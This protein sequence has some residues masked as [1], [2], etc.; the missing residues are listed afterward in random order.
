VRST[1]QERI[2]TGVEGTTT[3]L[4]LEIQPG[5]DPIA[6]SIGGPDEEPRSFSGWIELTEAIEAARAALAATVSRSG[7]R[8]S[9]GSAPWGE[10]AG[11][12]LT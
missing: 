5:S 12:H 7:R 3:H 1:G 4:H 10:G 6:G 2:L 11:A 8:K 9:A